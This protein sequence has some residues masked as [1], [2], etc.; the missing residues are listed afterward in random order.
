MNTINPAVTAPNGGTPT[1]TAQ[2]N[3]NEQYTSFLR[4]LTAQVQNQDPLSPL[5]STQF[6]QQ[7]A[8]FSALEQQVRSNVNLDSIASSIDSLYALIA[9]QSSGQPILMES[10]WLPFAGSP[11]AFT[12]PEMEAGSEAVLKVR[13]SSGNVLS[14]APLGLSAAEHVWDGTTNTGESA[15]TG[16]MLQFSVDLYFDN[17]YKGSV[18]PQFTRA[19]SST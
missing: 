13:D 6:V 12:L 15:P 2:A 4:L 17:Q 1:S 16:G 9:G 18:A 19:G 8:T 3:A 14:T 10:A 11:V 7:L 5:D